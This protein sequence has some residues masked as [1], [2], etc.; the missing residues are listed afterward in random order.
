MTEGRNCSTCPARVGSIF[1]DVSPGHLVQLNQAKTTNQY[2]RG[3]TLFYEG[4][5]SHGLFCIAAGQINLMKNGSDGKEV[6][7]RLVGKGEMVGFRAVLMDESFAATAYVS[8]DAQVCFIEKRFIRQLIAEDNDLALKILT[9]LSFE[10][11]SVETRLTDLTNKS[12]RQRLSQLLLSLRETHGENCSEGTRIGVR[13]SRSELASM[14]GATPETVIRLLSEFR[15]LGY[16]NLK[17]KEIFVQSVDQ[18]LQE[19]ALDS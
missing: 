6:M 4:N 9:K 5:P 16:V 12:V 19:S 1:R 3:Q 2:R 11:T 10:L 14:I 13:L 7:L 17:R 8:G 18:L 15:D